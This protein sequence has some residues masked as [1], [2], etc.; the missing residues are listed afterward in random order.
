MLQNLKAG[1]LL[2]ALDGTAVK[3]TDEVDVEKEYELVAME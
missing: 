2:L 1:G 3:P